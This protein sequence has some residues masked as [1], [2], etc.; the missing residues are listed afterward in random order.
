MNNNCNLIIK[1]YIN[2]EMLIIFFINYKNN[3]INIQIKKK[4]QNKILKNYKSYNSIQKFTNI[5]I[6]LHILH[7]YQIYDI[8]IIKIHKNYT[9]Y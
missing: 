3:E 7:K 6:F 1:N 2:S 5:T 4:I 9:E 8:N